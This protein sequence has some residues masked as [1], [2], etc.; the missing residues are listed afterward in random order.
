M[1]R[2]LARRSICRNP[3]PNGKNELAGPTPTECN[4]TYTPAPAVS[5]APTPVA[6]FAPSPTLAPAPVNANATV[7]YSEADL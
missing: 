3:L 7:K 6:A 5:R 2:P 1:A 4:D